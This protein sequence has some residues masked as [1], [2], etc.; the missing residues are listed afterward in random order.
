MYDPRIGRFFSPDSREADYPMQSTYVFAANNPIR[1]VDENGEGPG[2]PP[3]LK[4]TAD[5]SVVSAYSI[6]VMVDLA[7]TA[8]LKSLTITST[9]RS[10][11]KQMEV[12]YY[13]CSLKNGV[14]K[15]YNTYGKAGDAVIKSYETMTKAGKSREETILEMTKTAEKVGFLS[16]HSNT[17]YAEHNTIDIDYSNLSADEYKR[18]KQSAL[19]DPRIMNVKG[20]EE[21]DNALHIEIEYV[22]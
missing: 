20:K 19:N 7:R 5:K 12:M 21:G 9:Y 8:N 10:P 11:Q 17:N 16:N 22:H 2:D 1:L 18:L 6:Q 13:N 14:S 15:G 3:A 4:F